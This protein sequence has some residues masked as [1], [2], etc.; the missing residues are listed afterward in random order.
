MEAGGGPRSTRR[1]TMMPEP[2]C[3][4]EEVRIRVEGESARRDPP[5]TPQVALPTMRGFYVKKSGVAV[6][7]YTAGCEGA[8]PQDSRKH[9]RDTAT[10]AGE[11]HG[12]A[13]H[14]A[15]GARVERPERSGC[16]DRAVCR[17]IRTTG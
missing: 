8:T 14:A 3:E 1:T 5:P 2:V 11:D 4:G 16:K 12:A 9:D 7:G 13:S 10:L 17:A 15:A 6:Y